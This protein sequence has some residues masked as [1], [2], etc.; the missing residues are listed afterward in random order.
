MNGSVEFKSQN[1]GSGCPVWVVGSL[2]LTKVK[3]LPLLESFDF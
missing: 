1:L 3:T 2:A